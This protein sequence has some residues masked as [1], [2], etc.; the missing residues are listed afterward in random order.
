LETFFSR[1]GAAFFDAAAAS[2]FG[3]SA[4]LFPVLAFGVLAAFAALGFFGPTD[5]ALG[6]FLAFFGLTVFF[7]ALV[8]FL[9]LLVFS[10]FLLGFDFFAVFFGPF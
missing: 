2:F 3:R 7:A 6:A 10:G 5:L 8:G 1:A 4:A 9:G